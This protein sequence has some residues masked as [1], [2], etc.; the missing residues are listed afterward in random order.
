MKSFIAGFAYSRPTRNPSH[1]GRIT[2]RAINEAIADAGLERPAIDGLLVG[3]SPAAS[4][5]VRGWLQPNLA[6]E[7]ALPDLALLSNVDVEGA[8][9][10]ATIQVA[11]MAVRSGFAKA[12]LCV[13]A[14]TPIGGAGPGGASFTAPTEAGSLNSLYSFCGGVGGLTS[15]ALSTREYLRRYDLPADKLGHIAVSN[16]R[17]AALNPEAMLRDPLDLA[18][19]LKS[20]S[21]SDPLRVLDCAFPVNGAFAAVVSN[22]SIARNAVNPVEILGHAQA[23]VRHALAHVICEDLEIGARAACGRALRMADRKITDMDAFELY[24]AFTIMSALTVEEYG[25]CEPGEALDLFASGA[26]A[27]GGKVPVSTGGGHTS[28]G[29]LQ[30][31]SPLVE[32]LLQVRREAGDR[33]VGAGRAPTVLVSNIGGVMDHHATMILAPPR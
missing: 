19:Y 32:G 22:E 14:D 30:G 11:A 4:A 16:R 13:F 26:T 21:V 27:P 29:Y 20:P 2:I 9:A 18:A 15:Y 31:V 12:V 25:L 8:S 33:Q 17:W 23:H 3:C 24:D 5:E 10:M 28:G 1:I 7:A 6:R